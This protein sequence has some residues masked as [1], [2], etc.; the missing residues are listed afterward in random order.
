MSLTTRLLALEQQ[1]ERTRRREMEQI[2]RSI[3]ES[4][5]LSAAE[6]GQAVV[7]AL[8]FLDRTATWRRDGLLPTEILQRLAGELDVPVDHLGAE[9]R[10]LAAG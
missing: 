4:H 10:M 9:G 8:Q 5:N 7:E 3:P 6:V 1:A 2:V